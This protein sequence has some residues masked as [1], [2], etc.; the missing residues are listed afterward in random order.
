MVLTPQ[1]SQPGAEWLR[2]WGESLHPRQLQA[3][4]T[5]HREHRVGKM[6][7]SCVKMSSV[8]I[9][10]S[11]FVFSPKKD[12]MLIALLQVR[13][14]GRW[15]VK[16]DQSWEFVACRLLQVRWVWIK[17]T[18]Q[19]QSGRLPQ[20]NPLVFAPL[21]PHGAPMLIHICLV[22]FNWVCPK[23][24][25]GIITTNCPVKGENDVKDYMII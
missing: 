3:L 9:W 4:Q 11:G 17:M 21:V 6:V 14:I 16:V 20:Q 19:Y 24:G 12:C 25:Y 7:E 2:G 10:G 8:K 5:W 22:G 15:S 23:L 18:N 13:S 1:P